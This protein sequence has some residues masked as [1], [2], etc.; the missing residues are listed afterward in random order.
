MS[1]VKVVKITRD[2]R[3]GMLRLENEKVCMSAMSRLIR[4]IQ[5]INLFSTRL[6][7]LGINA[8]TCSIDTHSL[9]RQIEELCRAG[10]SAKAAVLMRTQVD[11]AAGKLEAI[12]RRFGE[13]VQHLQQRFKRWAEQ[14]QH[15][16]GLRKNLPSYASMVTPSEWPQADKNSIMQLSKKAASGITV[17]GAFRLALNRTSIEILANAER[18]LGEA[19]IALDERRIE[20]EKSIDATHA[21]F[22]SGKLETSAPPPTKLS[23]YKVANTAT[24]PSR[25]DDRIG[26]KLDALLVKVACLQDTGAWSD[27]QHRMALIA[28]EKDAGRRRL[29]YEDLVL[30]CSQRINN[31]KKIEA[32]QRTLDELFDGA[33]HATGGPVKPIIEELQAL[34]RS[35]SIKPLDGLRRRLKEAV[36]VQEEH[37][38]RESKRTAVLE[39]LQ[40]LGYDLHEGMETAIIRGGKLVVQKRGDTEYTVS[41]AVN[42]DLSMLQAE[43]IRYGESEDTSQQQRLRDKEREESWCVDHAKLLRKLAA[44]GLSTEFKLKIEP[45]ARPVRVVVD[46]EAAKTRKAV[47]DRLNRRTRKAGGS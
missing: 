15:L 22:I 44:K 38:E 25:E 32:W 14:R 31:L 18:S 8:H 1:G 5:D 4:T 16:L 41:I 30:E 6:G 40:E 29:L 43:M 3:G 46:R 11:Q 45:G 39:S 7:D 34:R 26:K 24:P 13:E 9:Q 21:R 23:D 10:Q 33:A 2:Q 12:E 19:Q 35:G 27:I 17:P 42:D 20:I 36:A 47:A 37:Q 28:A